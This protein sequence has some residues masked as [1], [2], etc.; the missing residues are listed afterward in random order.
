MLCEPQP[1]FQSGDFTPR[2]ERVVL[3]LDDGAQPSGRIRFAEGELPS[4]PVPEPEDPATGFSTAESF[5]WC[6]WSNLTR[7]GEY[8]LLE[9]RR[10]AT[11]LE[12]LVMPAEVWRPWCTSRGK[13][14]EPCPPGPSCDYPIELCPCGAEGCE[15]TAGRRIHFDFRIEGDEM[16]AFLI[17]T[18][19]LR[20]RRVQ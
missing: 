11:R 5:F 15:P 8:S 19:Q 18:A 7:G 17:T 6:A 2:S 1:P 4:S 13:M 14:A 16:E 3:V 12:F 9:S 20:L 10:S